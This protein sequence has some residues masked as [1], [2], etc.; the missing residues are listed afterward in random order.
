[1]KCKNCGKD[2]PRNQCIR[3]GRPIKKK[4]SLHCKVCN[5]V[6]QLNI[7]QDKKFRFTGT[8]PPQ[9]NQIMAETT[10]GLDARCDECRE[11][12]DRKIKWD[13]MVLLEK[14]RR[15]LL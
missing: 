10:Q 4:G 9:W 12:L 11:K 15:G 6:N 7:E 2:I 8:A 14:L 5:R 1:M 13:G 3:C